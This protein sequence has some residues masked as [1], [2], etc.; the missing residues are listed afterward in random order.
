MRC[1]SLAV[2]LLGLVF[3]LLGLSGSDVSALGLKTAPLEYKTTLKKDE[4]QQGFIDISNP[5]YQAVTVRTSVQALK[6]ID[7]QG[8]LQFYDDKQIS[9]GIMPDLEQ[10]TLGPREAIRM[11]FTISSTN[12]PKGDVYAAIFFT[13]DVQQPRNGV[14]QLVRVGT[15][16]S[17]VNQSAGARNAEISNISL[18]FLQLTDTVKGSYTVKNTN[19]SGTGFYPEVSISAWPAGKPKTMQS[20]LVFAGRERK[21][22]FSYQTGMGIHLVEVG[23][24]ASKKTQWVIALPAW[25]IIVLLLIIVVFGVEYLLFKKRRKLHNKIKP[26]IPTPTS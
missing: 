9:L 2:L 19:S 7:N 1:R 20:S 14:G 12:L 17:I 22:D 3:S 25:A 4:Q 5:S 11:S 18:P 16:L 15:I 23:Y 6:Q 21:N 13:S 26:Q 24:G 8:G 10:F